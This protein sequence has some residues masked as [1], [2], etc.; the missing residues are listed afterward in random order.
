MFFI[1]YIYS[2]L[3]HMHFSFD[4]TFRSFSISHN[5]SSYFDVKFLTVRIHVE[6]TIHL[7]SMSNLKIISR[8]KY[9]STTIHVIFF[10]NKVSALTKYALDLSGPKKAKICQSV[11]YHT[12]STV[13]STVEQELNRTQFSRCKATCIPTT[14]TLLLR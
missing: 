9:Y 8:S 14:N 3:P 6:P 11:S 1:M 10:V 2:R 7:I 13:D 5:V 12:H 4:F